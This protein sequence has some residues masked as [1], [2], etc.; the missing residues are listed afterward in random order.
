MDTQE[1]RDSFLTR[2][3]FIPGEVH[4]VYLHSDRILALGV[5]PLGEPLPLPVPDQVRAEHLMQ[6]REAGII[7]LG[8]LG[9]VTVDGEEYE[10]GYTTVMYLGRGAVDVSF[11]SASVQAPAAFYVF[12][13][14]SHQDLPTTLVTPART[15]VVELGSEEKANRRTLHQ[16]IYEGGTRS[17]QIAFGFTQ[18]HPGNTWNTMPAHTHERRT[19]CYL[20]FG[21]DP[22]DRVFHVMGQETETRH[23][24]VADREFVTSPA[25]SLHFGCGTGAYTFVWATAGENT[26][27][28]DMDAVDTT[29]MR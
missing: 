5:V 28:D 19:E 12:T 26:T 23:L 29:T 9:T 10:L 1:L 24:V 6:R 2:G 13:A 27:Y 3:L 21:M 14:I 25:W 4:G 7:N 18:V 16:C 11:R 8:G 15:N 17:S 22:G 20:Y